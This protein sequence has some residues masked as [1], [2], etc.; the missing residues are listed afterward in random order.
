M[1]L[2]V[3]PIPLIFHACLDTVNHACV[4]EDGTSTYL[5]ASE[6]GEQGLCISFLEAYWLAT[7]GG[8]AIDVKVGLF[9]PGFEFDVLVMDTAIADSNIFIL[10]EMDSAKD[11]LDK[12]ICLNNLHLKVPDI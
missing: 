4:S 1:T 10:D 11:K 2:L 8:Q 7:V 12:F 6:R 9:Q 5:P 3:L